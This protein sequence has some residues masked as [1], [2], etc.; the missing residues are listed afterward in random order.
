MGGEGGRKEGRVVKSATLEGGVRSGRGR[1][2]ATVSESRAGQGESAAEASAL[3]PHHIL[4]LLT[5]LLPLR[6]GGG[7]VY[8]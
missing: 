7:I 5:R 6:V 8:D 3:P 2:V 1:E 4:A